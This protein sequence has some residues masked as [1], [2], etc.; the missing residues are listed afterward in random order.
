MSLA[1]EFGVCLRAERRRQGLTQEALAKMA[2][3]NRTTPSLLER[4]LREPRLATIVALADALGV[5]PS[6]L[7]AG[8]KP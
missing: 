5:D 8:L 3:L 1:E 2:G 4:G 7:V 6:I